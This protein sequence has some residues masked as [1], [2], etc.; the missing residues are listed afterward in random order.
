MITEG[1]SD[2]KLAEIT[3]GERKE[4]NRPIVLA[5]YN[6]TWPHRFRELERIIREVLGDMVLLL[7]HV[8]STSVP[9][10]CAKPIIDLILDFGQER[11]QSKLSYQE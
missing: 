3:I 8:G 10:L 9:G 2:Q 1:Y 4:W 11:I 5:D 6:F 7:E